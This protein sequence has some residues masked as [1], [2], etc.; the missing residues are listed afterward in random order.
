MH[1]SKETWLDM[2]CK[3]YI[4]RLAPQ[5]KTDIILYKN[6]ERLE[7]AIS[8][9]KRP[10]LLDPEGEEMDSVHFA[11]FLEK[12]IE[13]RGS[14]LFF[15]IGGPVGFTPT[16]KRGRTLIRLSLMT[17]T[18]QLVRLILLEQVYRAFEIMRCSPYHK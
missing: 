18:H 8:L 10:I 3:D 5:V 14:T 7:T 9:D 11:A 4:S 6:E 13:K 12:E 15:A 16:Q 1:K 17:F 2:G